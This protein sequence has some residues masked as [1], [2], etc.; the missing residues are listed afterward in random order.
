MKTNILMMSGGDK[1]MDQFTR[2]TAPMKAYL[3]ILVF[4]I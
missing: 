4:A 3:A 2:V 1:L